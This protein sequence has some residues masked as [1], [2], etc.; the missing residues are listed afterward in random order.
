MNKSELFDELYVQSINKVFSY[1]SACFNRQIAEDLSQ[2]VYLKAWKRLNDAAFALP[3]NINAWLFRIVINVKNDYLREKY[4]GA[5]FAEFSDIDGA[6]CE[7]D[8]IDTSIAVKKAFS[9]LS[10]ND[11]EVLLL[12]SNGFSSEEMGK[13]LNISASAARSR[14]ATARNS[15]KKSLERCGVSVE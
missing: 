10:F 9:L 2:I 6:M 1:F 3:D 15:F 14:L 8:K 7:T 12:K 11:K 13:I 4:R 5:D